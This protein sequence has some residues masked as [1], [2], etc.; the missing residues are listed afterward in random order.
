MRCSMPFYIRDLSIC[1]FW[2][3][4]QS[5]VDTEGQLKSG[6][7][8]KLYADFQLCGDELPESLCCSRISHM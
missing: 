8:K 5:P 3:W 4:N 6:G 7:G 2:S 1:G